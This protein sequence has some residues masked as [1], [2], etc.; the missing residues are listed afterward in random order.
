MARALLQDPS[1]IASVTRHCGKCTALTGSLL[2]AYADFC[3]DHRGL[4]PA[5]IQNRLYHLRWFQTFLHREN[6]RSI[7][8]VELTHLDA[9]VLERAE[10]MR[11]R[12]LQTVADALRSFF[13]YLHLQGVIGR[14]LAHSIA[15]PCRFSGDLHPKYIPWEQV[16]RLLAGIE[17]TDYAGKRDYA[18]LTLLACHGLRPREVAAIT[19]ADIDWERS[20]IF[21]R[22]RK[23][24]PCA[25]LPLSARAIEALRGCMASRPRC[26]FPEVFVT[27]KNPIKPLGRR[28]TVFASLRLHR[29]FGRRSHPFGAYVLRHSFAKAMLDRGAKLHEISVLLGHKSIRSTLI[30]TRID[31][32]SLRE[33]SDNYAELLCAEERTQ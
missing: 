4:R 11:T 5:T 10:R 32:E 30:Y 31:T 23:D 33:V 16:E 28:L 15:L 14:D 18:I 8:D 25:H 21:L 24:G 26:S 29:R 12:G 19:G 13:R 1:I 2:A 6:I 9:F 20:S 27:A 7:K 17:R 22:E 3:R